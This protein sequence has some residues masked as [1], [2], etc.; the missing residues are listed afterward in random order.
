M[1]HWTWQWKD[2]LSAT[3]V[4]QLDLECFT[5]IS[6]GDEDPKITQKM[7]QKYIRLTDICLYHQ[8]LGWTGH[9]VQ[10]LA[11]TYQH[12]VT[13]NRTKSGTF[14]RHVP[15]NSALL[16]S[17]F[18]TLHSP[19]DQ[20]ILQKKKISVS[21]S[22]V[23]HNISNI[24]LGEKINKHHYLYRE[25]RCVNKTFDFSDWQLYSSCPGWIKHTFGIIIII[26]K[27]CC[28]WTIPKPNWWSILMT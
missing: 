6:V 23:S 15:L 25:N 20:D 24:K 4:T 5:L 10:L 3:S 28:D 13:G 1:V 18:C 12:Q 21:K 14:V 2:N 11:A 9:S 26:I 16:T 22:S 17:V 8:V 27:S 7:E 19:S